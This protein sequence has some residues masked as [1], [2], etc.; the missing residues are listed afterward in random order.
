MDE[1]HV[2][3]TKYVSPLKRMKSLSSSHPPGRQRTEATSQENQGRRL[4]NRW[5]LPIAIA[6]YRRS[7][8]RSDDR[9]AADKVKPDMMIGNDACDSILR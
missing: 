1:A 2:P 7:D 9:N 6:A 3:M 5:N 4:R 8:R